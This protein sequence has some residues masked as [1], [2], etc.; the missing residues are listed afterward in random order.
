MVWVVP[1]APPS[2]VAGIGSAAAQTPKILDTLSSSEVWESQIASPRRDLS[3]RPPG[4]TGN[5]D[6][7]SRLG[8]HPTRTPDPT[9]TGDN[10][11]TN[12]IRTPTPGGAPHPLHTHTRTEDT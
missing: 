11:A 4:S 10:N 7:A 1:E 6:L 2:G 9:T 12:P 3:I 5:S 8:A